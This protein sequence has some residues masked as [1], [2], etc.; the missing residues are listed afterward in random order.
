MFIPRPGISFVSIARFARSRVHPVRTHKVRWLWHEWPGTRGISDPNRRRA[1]EQR[2]TGGSSAP[3]G[4]D[5]LP[6]VAE[7]RKMR[8]AGVSRQKSEGIPQ[9]PSALVFETVGLTGRLGSCHSIA[10]RGSS[11][12]PA[13]SDLRRPSQSAKYRGSVSDTGSF[14]KRHANET[15]G[16]GNGQKRDGWSR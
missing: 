13:L 7:S 11:L 5:V 15:L 14:A 12:R 1:T 2:E 4:V 16:S 3:R 9:S 8:R 6:T 10:R